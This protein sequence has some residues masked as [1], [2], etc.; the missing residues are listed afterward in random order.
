ML[1]TQVHNWWERTCSQNDAHQWENTANYK[2]HLLSR[3]QAVFSNPA[4]EPKYLSSRCTLKSSCWKQME[5]QFKSNPAWHPLVTAAPCTYLPLAACLAVIL[6]SSFLPIWRSCL[7]SMEPVCTAFSWSQNVIWPFKAA[8]AS[9]LPSGRKAT[10]RTAKNLMVTVKNAVRY[11]SKNI[12][13]IFL[14]SYL[15]H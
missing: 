15:N 11:F 3:C 8:T 2:R 12:P 13:L 7:P 4:S 1:A 6:S 10:T 5:K 9:S 14:G